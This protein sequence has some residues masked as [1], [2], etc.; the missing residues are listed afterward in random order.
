MDEG[1]VS[2]FFFRGNALPFDPATLADTDRLRARHGY[3]LEPQPQ[4]ALP[5]N[6]TYVQQDAVPQVLANAAPPVP[7]VTGTTRESP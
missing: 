7:R 3:R 4:A 5:G 2:A 1:P 6:T